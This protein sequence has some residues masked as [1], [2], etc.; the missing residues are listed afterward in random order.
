M[1]LVGAGPAR[2]IKDI[3]PTCESQG[4]VVTIDGGYWQPTIERRGDRIVPT[5]AKGTIKCRPVKPTVTNTDTIVM[6]TES[7]IDMRGGSFAPGASPE[8]DGSPEIEFE[9]GPS[10]DYPVQLLLGDGDDHVTA[11]VVANRSLGFNL[12][13]STTDSDADILLTPEK[14]KDLRSGNVTL[15]AGRGDD[16]IDA[17]GGAGFAARTKLGLGAFFGGP[18]RDTIIGTGGYDLIAGGGGRDTID[19]G[20]KADEIRTR[21]R[22]K[23]L[24]LCGPGRDTLFR[25]RR[26]RGNGCE[27]NYL[28]G[29]EPPPTHIPGPRP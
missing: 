29:L 28:P 23:D 18:G 19:A 22:S 16:I 13:P 7:T 27:R 14:R 9:I 11:G 21:D 6:P 4:G 3:P 25:D 12:N 10:I 24:V 1:L 5:Y 15:R 20:R 2:A 8:A 26:D 17:G